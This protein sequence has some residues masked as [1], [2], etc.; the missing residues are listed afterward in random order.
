MEPGENV[1]AKREIDMC[2]GPLVP[3]LLIFSAPLMLSGIL[4][5]TFTAVNMVIVGR[6]RGSSALAAVGAT[7]NVIEL[8]LFVFMGLATGANVL[9]ARYYGA[10][11]AEGMKQT[12][13]T[14]ITASLAGG[15]LIGL[16]GIL[17]TRPLLILTGTP[18]DIIGQAS[19]YMRIY[20]AGL[21][22]I[23]LYNFG[24]AVLRG[25]GDT[26]SPLYF[27]SAAGV[28]NVGL[29]LFFVLGLGMSVAG[30][31][32]ASVIAQSVSAGLVLRRLMRSGGDYAVSLRRLRLNAQKLG[33]MAKIG[34][35]EG[36]QGMMFGISNVLIQTSINS[37]GTD[38]IAGNTAAINIEG[39]IFATLNALP[40]A[41]IAFTG[42]NMGARK[43]GNITRI[44]FICCGLVVLSSAVMCTAA[45]LFRAPLLS[46][47]ASEPAVLETGA[48]RILIICS[49]YVL[50]CLNNVTTGTMRGMGYS[51]LPAVVCLIGICALRV[52]WVETV[53][54]LH[55]SYLNLMLSY[56]ISWAITLAANLIC[57]FIV[58]RRIQ[59]PPP[60][61]PTALQKTL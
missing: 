13:H 6:F 23:S 5:L 22:V 21:P 61:Q 12:V 20:F 44:F 38:V 59:G 43:Y 60:T 58:R 40:Q 30:V 33:M 27:L 41:A 16:A 26:K 53:F 45:V 28:I 34:I 31:A 14:A 36:L 32:V 47:Y 25:V 51:V 29:N 4:Q 15:V 54:Q 7:F 2:T 1:T 49:S 55:R 39:F 11:D 3:K 56:P 52:V 35:P 42:Q 8:L 37:F 48:L 9:V 24:G 19:V 50:L 10:R 18:E 57:L 46:I 17:L